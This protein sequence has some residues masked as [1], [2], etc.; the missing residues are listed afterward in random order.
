M[1]GNATGPDACAA[2]IRGSARGERWAVTPRAVSPVIEAVG[3]AARAAERSRPELADP[4]PVDDRGVG[5][6]QGSTRV[7]DWKM[8][9]EPS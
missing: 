8:H 7:S 9:G 4:R 2:R 6:F 3:P 5:I 1:A